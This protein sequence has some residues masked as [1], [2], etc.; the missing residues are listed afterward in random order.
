MERMSRGM[1]IG[2]DVKKTATKRHLTD[3]VQPVR[4]ERFTDQDHGEML[5]DALG[6]HMH[7]VA[8]YG[9]KLSS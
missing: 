4:W 8:A 5:E 3:I 1:E 6:L 9:G 2:A 7:S